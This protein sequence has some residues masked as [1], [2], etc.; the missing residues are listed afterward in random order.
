MHAFACRAVVAPGRA[1]AA[2]LVP[3]GADQAV[4]ITLHDQLK[5]GLGNAAQEMPILYGGS[6]KPSNAEE[7][8]QGPDVNGGLIGGASL[9]VG[10]FLELIAIAARVKA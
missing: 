3:T 1:L 8:F 5:N 9:E 6:C 4:D 7:L 10:S 2:A